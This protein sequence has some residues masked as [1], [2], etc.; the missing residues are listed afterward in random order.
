MS[1]F[2][3]SLLT[4]SE[5]TERLSAL[6]TEELRLQSE[7]ADLR[8]KSSREPEKIAPSDICAAVA[9]CSVDLAAR[10]RVVLAVV[11]RVDVLR[12]DFNYGHKYIVDFKIKFK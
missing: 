12:R 7:L 9:A 2:S 1:W 3:Q 5:A 11:E 10:R 8:A 4:Q 6:K